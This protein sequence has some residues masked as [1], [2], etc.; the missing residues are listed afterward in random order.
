MELEDHLFFLFTQVLYRRNR[1]LHEAMKPVGLLLTEY[2]VLSVTLRKGPLS[3]QDLAQWTAYERTRL[4]HILHAM[5][6]RGWVLR[7]SSE[8]DR[9]TVM[10]QITP[11]G[12]ALFR[13]AKRVVEKLTS[14]IM[15]DN[16]AK[17][18]DLMRRALRAMGSRLAEMGY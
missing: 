8:D 11:A 17:D 13:K 12:T 6:E 4:T 16:S 7:S 14:A 3:M 18:V 15:S 9:R 2:R 5:E 10:V 1:A